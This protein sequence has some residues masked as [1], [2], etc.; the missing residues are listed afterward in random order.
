MVLDVVEE[1]L[2]VDVVVVG[3][4]PSYTVYHSESGNLG[5]KRIQL[6]VC[7]VR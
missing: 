2:V 4:G 1:V 5:L 6:E 3:G 7:S